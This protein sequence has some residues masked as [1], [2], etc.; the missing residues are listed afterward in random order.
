M[1]KIPV[2]V[3]LIAA[4][5]LTVGA[6]SAFAAKKFNTKVTINYQAGTYSDS[7]FGDV[8]SKKDACEKNRNVKVFRKTSGDDDLV[9]NDESDDDGEYSVNLGDYA[10]NGKYYAKVPRK[11][12][13]NNK[14][15]KSGES[16]TVTVS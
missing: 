3:L 9:G 16:D 5:C 12:L 4:L 1:K 14:V 13:N 8:K 2:A 10:E 15:C 11:E 6:G 7:F